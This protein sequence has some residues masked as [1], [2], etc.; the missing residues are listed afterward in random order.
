[1]I[2][3]HSLS[4]EQMI[5][6]LDNS[7]AAVFVSAVDDRRLL[8][9]NR[10]AKELFP[11]ADRPCAAC[12]SIAGFDAPCPFCH[13]GEMN[14]TKLTVREYRHPHNNRIFQL[15]G[16]LIDWDGQPAHIEY[17]LDITA[18]TQEKEH[19]RKVEEELQATFRSMPCGLC[20]YQ[21]DGERIVPIF[22]NPAFYEI[23]GYS[24]DHIR[25]V[26]QNTDYLGV[27][28]EDLDLLRKKIESFIFEGGTL[29]HI[30]RLYHDK[31]GEY[32][33][34]QMEGAIQTGKDGRKL[35]YG[36]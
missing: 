27:H 23:A 15:S 20:V 12:F 29:R 17:I 25:S 21:V 35:L 22:H 5:A 33:W 14:R 7:P 1:M 30:Y 36:V 28:P 16:K 31:R 11:E 26:E 2:E 10:R 6:V 8:Y 3:N 34:I 13:A 32:R 9:V 4:E 24:D 19:R 18:E